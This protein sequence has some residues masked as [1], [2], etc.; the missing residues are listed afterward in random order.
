MSST[1]SNIDFSFEFAVS[2]I[3]TLVVASVMLK[4]NPQ[5]STIVIVIFLFSALF[6]EEY[7][8]STVLSKNLS[9]LNFQ[10]QPLL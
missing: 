6:L 1:N 2:T 5:M 9:A 3:V 7:F 4:K 8:S 10:Q